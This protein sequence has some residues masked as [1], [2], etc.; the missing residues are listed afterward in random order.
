MCVSVCPSV[1][2]NVYVCM[3]LSGYNQTYRF[4]FNFKQFLL[5]LKCCDLRNG[6]SGNQRWKARLTPRYVSDIHITMLSAFVSHESKTGTFTCYIS[7][8]A[9]SNAQIW[10]VTAVLS[11]CF[12]ILIME[13]STNFNS[14][15]PKL[16]LCL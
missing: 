9:A 14:K 3:C 7:F 12:M 11:Y 16:S 10:N 13:H 5:R 6:Q 2:V 1:C 4:Q 15:Q 8:P